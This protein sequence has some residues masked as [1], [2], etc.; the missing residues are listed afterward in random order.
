MYAPDSVRHCLPALQARV[1]ELEHECADARDR[2]ALLGALQRAFTGLVILRCEEQVAQAMLQTAF[3]VL[4]FTRAI[5]FTVDADDEVCQRFVLDGSSTVEPG[6]DFIGSRS[7]S[8]FTSIVRDAGTAVVGCA[9]EL[10]APLIDTRGWYVATA[11]EQSS[12]ARR[13]LY[14]DGHPS[15][16]PREWEAELISALATIGGV[17]LENVELMAQLEE[18]ATRDPLTGLYNRRAFAERLGAEVETARRYGRALAYV[19]I[20]VDDFKT[21]NDA[22]GHAHGDTVLRTLAMTLLRNSRAQDV[23][24]RYAGDEFVVLLVDVEPVLAHTLVERLSLALRHTGLRCSLGAALLPRDASDAAALMAK[25]DAAL[26]VTKARGK[27]G[28]TFA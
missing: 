27:D 10:C 5:Y 8:A 9:G 21:I 3:F 23:V 13:V 12:R 18:L 16:R 24:A 25:A 11:L 22:R 15:A 26:Y 17:A 6:G 1:L 20:D 4:G 19:M 7:G 2:A 14:V 28:F